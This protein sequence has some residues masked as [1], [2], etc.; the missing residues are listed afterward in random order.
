MSQFLPRSLNQLAD[1]D[2][3][4]I[5]EGDVEET[6]AHAVAIEG[7]E[8][9]TSKVFNCFLDIALPA[10]VGLIVLFKSSFCS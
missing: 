2:V 4:K 6:Y 8:S 1:Y 10:Q 9:I 7:Y 3:G 5:E